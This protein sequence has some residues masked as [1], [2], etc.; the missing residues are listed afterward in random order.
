MFFFRLI[1]FPCLVRVL[2]F[3]ASIRPLTKLAQVKR[4][5]LVEHKIQAKAKLGCQAERT[6]FEG[7]V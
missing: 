2:S 7:I 4:A 5:Q 3:L 6:G 1:S